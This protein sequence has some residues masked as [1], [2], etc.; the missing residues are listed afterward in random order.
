MSFPSPTG[1]S[2]R[3]GRERPARDNRTL[4][5]D[6]PSI[7]EPL[8]PDPV[9]V[10]IYEPSADPFAMESAIEFRSEANDEEPIDGS[11]VGRMW[12]NYAAKAALGDLA[13]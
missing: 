1:R 11:S 12:A 3:F 6:D 10:E 2:R 4:S 13:G 7:A 5:P 8:L 9:P